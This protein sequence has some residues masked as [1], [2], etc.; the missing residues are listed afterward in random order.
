V[1][2]ERAAR[3]RVDELPDTSEVLDVLVEL[4][5]REQIVLVVGERVD[6]RA[7]VA[8]IGGE[9]KD[10]VEFVADPLEDGVVRDR[11]LDQLDSLV[12]GD[13]RPLRREEV[14]DD[15]DPP[16]V[17]SQGLAD[18]VPA[19]EP[20]TSDDEERLAGDRAHWAGCFSSA[21]FRCV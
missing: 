10:E 17:A 12:S 14:V 15:D 21:S 11:A 3:G 2:G 13:V 9:M 19:D 5:R 4:Q 18:H 20:C 1:R 8:V 16:R 7:L 6:D